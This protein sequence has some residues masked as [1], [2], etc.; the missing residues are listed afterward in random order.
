MNDDVIGKVA[1]ALHVSRCGCDGTPDPNDEHDARAA[2]AAHTDYLLA[3]GS[4]TDEEA[5]LAAAL[6]GTLNRYAAFRDLTARAVAQAVADRDAAIDQLLELLETA[7][8]REYGLSARLDAAEAKLARVEALLEPWLAEPS[9]TSM[10]RP[11]GGVRLAESIRAALADED[12][13]A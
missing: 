10:P 6:S 4:V 11:D 5:G 12:G 8:N 9:P 2:V 7:S 1:K 3:L 13:D